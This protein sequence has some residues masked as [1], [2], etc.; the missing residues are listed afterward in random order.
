MQIGTFK[1]DR[2]E[3]A[4]SLGD[5]GTLIPLSVALMVITGLSATSVLLMV[6]IFYILSG[7]YYRLPIPVQPLKV[8]AAIAIASPAKISL[9]IIAA[10]GVIFGLILLSLAL[11]GLI[12]WLAKFFTKPI[13]RG[14]QLGLGLILINKGIS[15]VLRPELFINK[16]SKTFA[17]Q[18]WAAKARND[19]AVLFSDFLQVTFMTLFVKEW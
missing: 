2:V 7:L 5:L 9:P 13:V 8:V 16:Q 10:S 17:C 11:T 19:E 12:D 3:F 15:F 14:I 1:F 18:K 6:G 4:G